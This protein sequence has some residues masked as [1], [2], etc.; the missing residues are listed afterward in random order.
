MFDEE[1]NELSVDDILEEE[2]AG[3]LTT[4]VGDNPLPEDNEPPSDDEPD[5]GE[6]GDAEN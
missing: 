6:E 3:R 4:S 1:D 2:R 5:L